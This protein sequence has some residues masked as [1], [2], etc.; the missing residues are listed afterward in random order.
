M[1][2]WGSGLASSALSAEQ[3]RSHAAMDTEKT[4]NSMRQHRLISLAAQQNQVSF[5]LCSSCKRSAHYQHIFVFVQCI[6]QNPSC[7]CFLFSPERNAARQCCIL[8]CKKRKPGSSPAAAEQ[9]AS[10]CRLQRQCMHTVHIYPQRWFYFAFCSLLHRGVAG[11]WLQTL[12]VF[13][14]LDMI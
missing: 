14:H 3:A 12:R 5:L 10:R 7:F 4:W 6:L 2:P 11:I 8:G 1:F 13:W 9:W